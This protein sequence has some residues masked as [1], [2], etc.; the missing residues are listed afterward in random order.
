VLS[1][2]STLRTSC[3]S[4][5]TVADPAAGSRTTWSARQ[6]QRSRGAA[7]LPLIS[8]GGLSAR[9]APPRSMEILRQALSTSAA[10]CRWSSC[11]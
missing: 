4:M 2:P 8:P 6:N 10:R 3:P 1:K 7:A 11:P 5:R 9:S